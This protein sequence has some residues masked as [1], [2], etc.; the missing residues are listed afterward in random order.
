MGAA[1]L[2]YATACSVGPEVVGFDSHEGGSAATD[3]DASES[4]STDASATATAAATTVGTA[5]D[6][7]G[8][9]IYDV[10]AGDSGDVVDCGCGSELGFSYIWIA[11]SEAST[12]SKINTMTMV[13]EGRYVTRADSAGNPSRTSVSLSGRMAAVAN[14]AGGVAAFWTRTEFCD[15]NANGVPGLQTSSGPDDV[16]PYGTDDCLAWYTDFPGYTTQRPIAWLPGA[17]D[18]STCEYR[19]E[20]V[21]TS[22]CAYMTD[23]DI[24]AHRLS[25]DDGSI[26]DTVAVEGFP[27]DGYGGYGGAVD[28]HGDFWITNQTGSHKLARIDGATL[29]TTIWPAPVAPYGITVDHLGRP[30][31][32]SDSTQNSNLVP[33]LVGATSAA[34]FDPLTETWALAQNQLAWGQSGLQEDQQGRMW[35]AY[36]AY[37]GDWPAGGGFTWIDTATLEVG[38]AIPMKEHDPTFMGKGISVDLA[39]KVWIVS[40][41]GNAFRYDPET[42]QIDSVGGLG[43]AYTY[44]DMTGWGLQNA[45]CEPAG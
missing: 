17:L 11:N 37:N 6:S 8:G 34:V 42:E 30:W 33:G 5:A 38:P 12:V 27:C 4:S 32:T 25:G 28:S 2:A 35:V 31:L 22:G 19:E 13:E 29:E 26:L 23:T 20:R 1:S 44:S 3:S 15:P 14:R 45:A 24:W 18:P 39:G 36:Y 16:L 9:V 40:S 10:G 7:D 43:Y 21:W 41:S